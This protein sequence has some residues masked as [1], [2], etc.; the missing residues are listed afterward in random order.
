V[1]VIK[2][3]GNVLPYKLSTLQASF[4]QLPN[5]FEVLKE[6][7]LQKK[8]DSV[9]PT[10]ES[11]EIDI[12]LIYKNDRFQIKELTNNKKAVLI[13]ALEIESATCILECDR[14]IYL[15]ADWEERLQMEIP[16]NYKTISR[17]KSKFEQLEFGSFPFVVPQEEKEYHKYGLQLVEHENF[18]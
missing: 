14:E 17:H 12:H 4:E 7:S 1:H 6:R 5:N 11:K 10:L 8:I 3:S 18:I 9:Y 15:T 13:D 2:P 16:I